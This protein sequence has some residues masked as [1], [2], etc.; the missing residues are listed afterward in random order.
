[1]FLSI[2]IATAI[3]KLVGSSSLFMA[4][5]SFC[6]SSTLYEIKVHRSLYAVWAWARECSLQVWAA[7]HARCYAPCCILQPNQS[8]CLPASHQHHDR[9]VWSSWCCTTCSQLSE[10]I[11]AAANHLLW[12]IKEGQVYK[13]RVGDGFQAHIAD[14]GY[15]SHSQA[16]SIY[17]GF[18]SPS[19]MWYSS[20][21]YFQPL[22]KQN[23]N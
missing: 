23:L 19:S 7:F 5:I 2:I 9:R 12:P 21:G 10:C 20:Q 14:M 6:L 16:Y 15:R 4:L 11:S 1:M 22:K 17:E 8:Y 13:M 18:C 3:W